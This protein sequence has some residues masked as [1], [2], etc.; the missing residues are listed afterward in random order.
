MTYLGLQ[1]I[2]RNAGKG[3]AS[4]TATAPASVSESAMI[5]L[6]KAMMSSADGVKIGS[7]SKSLSPPDAIKSDKNDLASPEV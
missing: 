3:F 5:T 6:G 7:F 2:D 4:A 1:N